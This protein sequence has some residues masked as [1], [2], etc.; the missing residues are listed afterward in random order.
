MVTPGTLRRSL[1][2]VNPLP[3]WEMAGWKRWLRPFARQAH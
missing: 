1:K 3:A 2:P